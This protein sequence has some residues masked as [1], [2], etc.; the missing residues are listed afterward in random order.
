MGGRTE[1]LEPLLTRGS[2]QSL[3]DRWMDGWMDG[4]IDRAPSSSSSN[5]RIRL[6]HGREVSPITADSIALVKGQPLDGPL[7]HGENIEEGED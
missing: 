4:G 3:E 6:L 7:C 5:S 2:A 1:A